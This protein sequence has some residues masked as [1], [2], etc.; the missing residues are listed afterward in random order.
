MICLDRSRQRAAHS[1]RALVQ[2]QSELALKAG[3][4]PVAQ[5]VEHRTFNAVVAGSSPARLTIPFFSLREFG[6]FTGNARWQQKF[7]RPS[8]ACELL[9]VRPI[10]LVCGRKRCDNDRKPIWFCVH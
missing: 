9:G 1:G 3:G 10:A 6:F 7:L 2:R 4:G 8:A 5:L